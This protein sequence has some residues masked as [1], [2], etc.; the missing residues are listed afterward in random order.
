V[1]NWNALAD[2]L[3]E[4]SSLAVQVAGEQ[5][6]QRVGIFD[7]EA[8]QRWEAAAPFVVEP[9]PVDLRG[10]LDELLD[11]STGERP[12]LEAERAEIDAQ[13]ARRRAMAAKDPGGAT[14]LPPLPYP[15]IPANPLLELVPDLR[16]SIASA[17]VS[18]V[19]IRRSLPTEEAPWPE[20]AA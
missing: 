5:L 15:V 1:T 17:T 4:R 10:F 16:G 11:A 8:R 20:R 14:D 13:N 19:E 18:G 2:L 7:R 3:S 6:L 12:N 9:V